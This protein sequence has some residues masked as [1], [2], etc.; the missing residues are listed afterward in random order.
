MAKSKKR[1]GEKAHRQRVEQRN[2]K[3]KSAQSAMQKMFN[4]AMKAQIEELKKNAESQTGTTENT[5]G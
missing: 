4:E 1:G 3:L 5:E 2:V